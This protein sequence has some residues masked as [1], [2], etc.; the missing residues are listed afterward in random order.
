MLARGR[1]SMKVYQF[2]GPANYH[3]Y[4]AASSRGT[5]SPSPGPGICPECTDSRQ[6]RV[7]PLLLMWEPGSDVIG[8]FTWPSL[9]SDVVVSDGVRRALEPEF[10]CMAFYSVEMLQPR[11]R[12]RPVGSQQRTKPRVQVPYSGPPLWDMKPTAW[13]GVDQDASGVRLTSECSTCGRLFWEPGYMVNG[14]VV[15]GRTWQGADIF[16]LDAYPSR[17]FCTER[18]KSFVEGHGF[19]N[20]AFA[21][22]GEIGDAETATGP[23]G[24]HLERRLEIEIDEARNT[25]PNP[26]SLPVPSTQNDAV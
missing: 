4:A 21:L 10:C 19:T 5:W 2:V 16:R 14:I 11:A 13:C 26:Q 17:S 23:A 25:V 15:D 24:P 12:P 20:V 18:V 1:H 9:D 6:E 22:C 3:D 8:D 7:P